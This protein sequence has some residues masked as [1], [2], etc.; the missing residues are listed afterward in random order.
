MA[1]RVT[2]D[3]LDLALL[4]ALAEDA[5]VGHLQLSRV[6]GVARGTVSARIERL[7]EMGVIA[8]YRPDVSTAVA[9]FGS[10]PS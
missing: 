6:M 7:E 2:L 9:G 10:R 8:G 1:A 5:R 4:T 3:A